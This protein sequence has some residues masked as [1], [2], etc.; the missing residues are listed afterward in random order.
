MRESSQFWTKSHLQFHTS[1]LVPNRESSS[2]HTK[3]RPRKR[4][5]PALPQKG[6]FACYNRV[7]GCKVVSC[8]CH[9]C[10]PL[11]RVKSSTKSSRTDSNKRPRKSSRTDKTKVQKECDKCENGCARDNPTKWQP[12][13]YKDLTHYKLRGQ[14]CYHC[15]EYIVP[16]DQWEIREIGKDEEL[17]DGG[18]CGDGSGW[19]KVH[20]MG[21]AGSARC[22][23]GMGV[24]ETER[25]QEQNYVLLT[26]LPVKGGTIK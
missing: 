17:A 18:L 6:W 11:S 7:N 25:W 1:S 3:K 14:K 9:L 20:N 21:D 4:R 10:E 15:N 24:G 13:H 8:C 12:V 5:L 26:G 22:A 23:V 16:R 2:T 19:E